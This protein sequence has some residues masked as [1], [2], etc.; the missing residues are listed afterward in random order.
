MGLNSTQRWQSTSDPKKKTSMQSRLLSS[1]QAAL[2]GMANQ[3]TTSGSGFSD[4]VC[5]SHADRV[6]PELKGI[7]IK[8]PAH[9]TWTLNSCQL[10]IHRPFFLIRR[11]G[12]CLAVKPRQKKKQP[13]SPHLSSSPP[14]LVGARP[15]VQL[16]VARASRA[17]RKLS[18]K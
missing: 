14:T 2:L 3:T 4:S 15:A 12:A 9:A 17:P 5:V 6:L 8:C 13:Y 11:P 1:P 7:R 16:T 10:L 18:Q